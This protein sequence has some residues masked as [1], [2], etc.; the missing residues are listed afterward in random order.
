MSNDLGIDRSG[1]GNNW[2][3]NNMTYSDQ[4]LDTPTNNFATFNAIDATNSTFSEGNLK[5]AHSSIPA[6]ARSTMSM[7]SGKWYYEIIGTTQYGMHGVTTFESGMPT[8]WLGN[9]PSGWAYNYTDQ[10]IRN[11]PTDYAYGDT[12]TT[13][14]IIGI[15]LDVDTPSITFYK[16]GVSQGTFTTN[17]PANKEWFFASGGDWSGASW[18]ANF[19]QDSSFAGTKTAQGNQDS[20]G[21][22]DFY[23]TP[24][25]GFLA[26]CTANLPNVAVK[27]SQHFN[28]VL[29]SGTGS[30]QTISGVGFQADFTWIKSRS[31]A[32]THTAFDILRQYGLL[33]PNTTQVEG[34][35]GGGWLRSWASD[36]FDVDV[37]GPI[38]TNNQTYVSWN[39][40]AN[41]SG[42]ANSNGSTN[43][44]VSANTDAGFSIVSYTG[45]GSNATVG[46]GLS[47]APEMVI[48]KSRSSVESWICYTEATGNTGYL[49][50]NATSAFSSS[51]TM[52]N[53]TSPT[54]SLFTVG[55][56]N[57]TN[58]NTQ[59]YIA[60]C[61]HSVDD[62]S[63]VGSYVGN[64]STDGTFIYTGFRPAYVMWKETS[65]GTHG[66]MIHD[67]ARSTYNPSSNYLRAESAAP[68]GSYPFAD[69]T[70]NGFKQ[71]HTSTWANGNGVNYIYIAF[72]ETPFK[73]SNAK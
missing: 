54:A 40:R 2:T 19:G 72:A 30:V 41:G 20:N 64:G 39:W 3:V 9:D 31:N 13:G 69:F 1:N 46:H 42:S 27:P 55:T 61:F 16:N 57:A 52:F 38:N 17:F 44:T 53:N 12:Y 62:Y 29:Y 21:I 10:H 60:Y 58:S 71:R 50:L 48:V 56:N 6:F 33:Y 66:W 68:E 24:P 34:N 73:Y 49:P 11:S 7:K 14:D 32:D 45:T 63:K 35:T 47:V 70:S 23:Y 26:L 28:T 22:G 67:N 51:S 5:F 15:A 18:I 59:T 8:H 36:G 65:A 43:S 25:S 4:M 37:A